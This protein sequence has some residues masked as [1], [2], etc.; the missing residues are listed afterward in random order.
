MDEQLSTLNIDHEVKIVH[1][2]DSTIKEHISGTMA[3]SDS[4]L[5]DAGQIPVFDLS[6]KIIEENYNTTI[7][8]LKQK[9]QQVLSLRDL[10]IDPKGY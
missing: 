4:A 1:S 5:I 3:T 9:M 10:F 7:F 2:A 6:R 8:S